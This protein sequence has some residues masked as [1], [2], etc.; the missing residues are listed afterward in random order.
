MTLPLN[1]ASCLAYL[2]PEA[3]PEKDFE[4]CISDSVKILNWDHKLGKLPTDKE[5]NDV[6]VKA[7]KKQKFKRIR[8]KR[9]IL[10]KE[11]DWMAGLDAPVMNNKWKKYRQN[12]RDLPSINNDPDK[13][14]FPSKPD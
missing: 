9:N 2:F 3:D 13:I 8:Q 4:V 12:L 14:I 11:T 7:E 1:T 10:L 5:I 6:S